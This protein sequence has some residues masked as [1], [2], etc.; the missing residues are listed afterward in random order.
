[1]TTEPVVTSEPVTWSDHNDDDTYVVL[2]PGAFDDFSD[3][4][5]T[6][7]DPGPQVDD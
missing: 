4:D 5:S 7:V 1:M 2:D 3:V 6:T